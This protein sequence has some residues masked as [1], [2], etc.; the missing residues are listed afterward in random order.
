[1]RVRTPRSSLLFLATSN[2]RTKDLLTCPLL[3]CRHSF[4]SLESCLQHVST[5][6][7]LPNAWYWCHQ[8]RRAELFTP[9]EPSSALPCLHSV[10]R[11]DSKLKRAVSFFKQMRRR[12]CSP[13]RYPNV[14]TLLGEP[15]SSIAT[16]PKSQNDDEKQ[17]TTE[18]G[19]AAST[20]DL[21]FFDANYLP[22]MIE[23]SVNATSSSAGRPRTLYDMEANALSPLRGSYNVEDNQQI[24]ELP[25]SDPMFNSVQLGDTVISEL[26]VSSQHDETTPPAVQSH[27]PSHYGPFSLSMYFRETEVIVSPISP[28][29]SRVLVANRSTNAAAP[30]SPLDA[31][32]HSTWPTIDGCSDNIDSESNHGNAVAHLFGY[33]DKSDEIPITNLPS[34]QTS[35][36]TFQDS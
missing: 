12:S 24:M 21:G 36:P 23:R 26:P 9:E 11:K 25:T 20:S 10:R 35:K 33:C 14:D 8:C 15:V 31:P 13:Q 29:F 16:H 17:C 30:V 28:N 4:D 19:E 6:Q 18:T 34:A 3:W 32:F 22:P 5:C 7:W 1:M 27:P 2:S